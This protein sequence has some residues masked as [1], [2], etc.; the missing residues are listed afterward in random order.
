[1]KYGFHLI[2][3]NPSL[4]ISALVKVLLFSAIAHHSGMSNSRP[5]L[6]LCGLGFFVMEILRVIVSSCEAENCCLWAKE[7]YQ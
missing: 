3:L 6:V 1:M 5:L 7:I 2:L 4:G